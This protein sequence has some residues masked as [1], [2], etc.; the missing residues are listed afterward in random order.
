MEV[1]FERA[2]SQDVDIIVSMEND[3][4]A[5]L[6]LYEPNEERFKNYIESDI[7]NKDKVYFIA[8]VED[9][10]V[11]VVAVDFIEMI[12]GDDV[13]YSATIDL[14]YVNENYRK[15]TI[16][17]NLFMLAIREMQKREVGSFIMAVEGNN[18]N[19][20]L[21]FAFA[22]VIL[23]EN[24]E[25]TKNGKTTRY[26]LGVNDLEKIL[27]YSFKEFLTQIVKTKKDFDNI[28]KAMPRAQE[29]AYLY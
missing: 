29:I 12:G 22:D 5:M 4:Y 14:I 27:S 26:I 15:G 1:K 25:Q 17:Y 9:E 28:L 10:K 23:E 21:H 7:A 20:F 3:L 11:G 19:K 2:S 13:D 24:E 16:A 6:D 18:P 8:K